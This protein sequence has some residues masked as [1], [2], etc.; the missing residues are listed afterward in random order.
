VGD[1]G[2][3]KVR[4]LVVDDS[5]LMQKA[6]LKMLGS[7]FDV[8]TADDG[9]DAWGKLQSDASIQ[10]VFT[11]LSMPRMDGYELLQTVRGSS[12]PG[13]LTLPIIVVTG[14]DN[15]ESARM[16]ALELGATDFI[17]K[18]FTTIDLL[19]RARAHANHQRITRELQAQSTR[20]VLTGL[21][22]RAGFL[23]RLQQD[24]AYARRHQQDLTLVRLEIDDFRAVFL[25]HGKDVAE[26][27]VVNVAQAIR[28][29]IRR[30]DTAARIGLGGFALSLPAGKAD[31]IAG[32]V[33]RL[34]LEVAALPAPEGAPAIAIS[35]S[36]AV[37]NPDVMAGPS[38][39]SA[40]DDCQAL[41][42]APGTVAMA[43][44]RA[45]A[46]EAAPAAGVVAIPAPIVA[47]PAPAP[48]VTPDP[49][50]V[51]ASVAPPPILI[52]PIL[53]E[54]KNGQTRPAVEKMPLLLNR[55]LPLFRLLTPN[56][57][58]HLIRF[59]QQMGA[60]R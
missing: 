57:R 40:L 12:E 46:A 17:T 54:I 27:W 16:R 11:D 31:G 38:A 32:M 51:P 10:V 35:L 6:A 59:L 48:A 58:E 29:R 50:A 3:A 21:A 53:D 39:Q 34:R 4:V 23:E 25:R 5:R 8:I 19:A 2:E 28:T 14:A 33:E 15:D 22:N 47:A 1:D 13:M 7:E 41:L 18:P 45:P 43:P 26:A 52:D 49:R 36:G 30:E 44:A 42:G 60:A 24:L 20:D 56:Q 9:V 37:F 55:L